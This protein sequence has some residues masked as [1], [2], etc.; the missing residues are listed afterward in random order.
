MYFATQ[1]AIAMGAPEIC[2]EV[3]EKKITGK[4][5]QYIL[6]SADSKN[7]FYCLFQLLI[8]HITEF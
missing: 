5:G 3:K 6:S 1:T 7:S 4:I 2:R 8:I